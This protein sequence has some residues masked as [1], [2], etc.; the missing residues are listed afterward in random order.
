MFEIIKGVNVGRVP[1][2]LL[3]LGNNV[4][5]CQVNIYRV[6]TFL[7]MMVQPPGRGKCHTFKL[8]RGVKW[9]VSL[10]ANVIY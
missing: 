9:Y 1:L 4:V 3:R 10:I 2:N 7:D 8:K 6:K 5:N